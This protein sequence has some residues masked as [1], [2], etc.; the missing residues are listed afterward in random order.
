VARS[1]QCASEMKAIIVRV[2]TSIQESRHVTVSLQHELQL[3][4]WLYSVVAACSC[5]MLWL[6]H[7][8]RG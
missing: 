1:G 8:G 2:S 3:R 4:C 6:W 7:A 5:R